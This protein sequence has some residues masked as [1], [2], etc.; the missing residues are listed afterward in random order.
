[1]MNIFITGGTGGIGKALV[2]AYVAAG[3]RV[4]I[5]GGEQAD[6]QRQFPAPPASLHFY[7][8]DV[9]DRAATRACLSEFSSGKLDLLIACAGINDG[10]PVAGRPLDFAR[11]ERIFQI[12]LVGAL[13]S[14]E[15]A[16]DNMLPN[17]QGRIA[18]LSSAAALSGYPQTPAYCAAKS[19]L[20]TLCE[21]L[22]LRYADRGISVTCLLP[23]YI[24]TPLA[25]ATHP[26]LERM[27]FVISSEKA[28]QK[29]M[30]A[31]EQGRMRFTF[32]WQIAVI[33]TLVRWLP[34]RL[35]RAL[36][37]WSEECA[38]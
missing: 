29:I 35:F 38:Q 26:E 22:S 18:V 28:A 36:F 8:L 34:R 37:K 10:A 32:P 31:I 16:L 7:C 3:H 6:F 25:R 9:T 2:D 23:G 21:S 20:V 14:I 1:M 24:D 17:R 4:G 30:R 13:H 12:N 11:A 27:P 33:S 5:C 19:A 15:A